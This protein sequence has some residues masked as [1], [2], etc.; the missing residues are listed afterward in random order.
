M[1]FK[2]SDLIARLDTVISAKQAEAKAEE[3]KAF[4]N[5][6]QAEKEWLENYADDWAYFA[7]DILL[8]LKHNEP[9]TAA[10]RPQGIKGRTYDGI[11]WY[12]PASAS[13]P[14]NTKSLESLKAILESVDDETVTPTALKSLGFTDISFLFAAKEAQ[15]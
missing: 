14:A 5:A 4:H 1:K 3:E 2:T 13:R 15:A 8:K 11:Q 12:A 6:G 10:I 7:K 9:I